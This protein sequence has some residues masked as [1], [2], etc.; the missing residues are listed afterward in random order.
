MPNSPGHPGT[1]PEHLWMEL[2]LSGKHIE[3]RVVHS[4]ASS[5]Y[6]LNVLRSR[7]L[8]GQQLWDV[9]IQTLV[10]RMLYA[11]PGGDPSMRSGELS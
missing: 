9:T 5:M 2:C 1:P 7:G 4:A 11:S 8:S 6:A 10:A 3:Q